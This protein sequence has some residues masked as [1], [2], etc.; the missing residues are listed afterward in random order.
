MAPAPPRPLQG[1]PDSA[2]EALLPGQHALLSLCFFPTKPQ[3][4]QCLLFMFYLYEGLA[5]PPEEMECCGETPDQGHPGHHPACSPP[6][7]LAS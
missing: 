7:G 5:L 4:E 3:G 1:D 2:G 6:V